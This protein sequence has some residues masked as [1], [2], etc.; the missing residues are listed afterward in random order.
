[1][2]NIWHDID[3]ERITPTDFFAVVEIKK[4]SKNKYELYQKIVFIFILHKNTFYK[5]NLF[6]IMLMIYINLY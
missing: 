6:L 3:E 4:G 5:Y 2:S 1:M